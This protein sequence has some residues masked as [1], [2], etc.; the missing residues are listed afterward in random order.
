[1]TLHR[2][3]TDTTV[4]V[5]ADTQNDVWL[6]Q[7]GVTL[8][9]SGS[10]IDATATA[11]FRTFFIEG[12]VVA[13]Y[14]AG[15]ALGVGSMNRIV[16]G[17]EGAVSSSSSGINIYTPGQGEVDIRNSGDIYG[18]SEGIYAY[19]DTFK[20]VND[21]TIGGFSSVISRST[22][23]SIVNNGTMNGM[24]GLYSSS[25]GAT[26][27]VNHGIL[28]G[29]MMIDTVAGQ[30][31]TIVNTGKIVAVIAIDGSQGNDVVTNSGIIDG[32]VMLH[33]GNDKFSNFGSF[34]GGMDFGAGDDTLILRDGSHASGTILMGAG[35]DRIEV[36][37]GTVDGL[38]QGMS[39]NDVYVVRVAGA[40]LVE[41]GTDTDLVL[42]DLDWRLG[43][44]FEHLYLDG[45][46]DVTGRGNALANGISGNLGDNL[47]MGYAGD[48]TLEGGEGADRLDGGLGSDTAAY[49]DSGV[50]VTVDL[51]KGRARGGEAQ[52]DTF[53][54]IENAAGSRFGDT[55]LG[56]KAANSLYG[57]EGADRLDGRGGDDYL[58]GGGGS[59]TFVFAKRYGTDTI[60]DFAIAGDAADV[61]DISRMAGVD[62]FRDL[63]KNHMSTEGDDAVFTFDDGSVLVLTGRADTQFQANHFLI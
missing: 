56:S 49:T 18:F 62:S 53:V 59:D 54:S 40:Q 24:L 57:D 11:S 8:A 7:Q 44:N 36:L 63:V 34:N 15:I 37:G 48:D 38:V 1:M 16:V 55:L 51:E 46:A 31:N 39:G 4:T 6:V 33:N 23:N 30:T 35:N 20:L 14:G 43:G 27:V 25:A 52:G 41:S 28:N 60:V 10:A 29:G 9:T 12:H 2:I 17:S 45:D 22:N 26:S 5:I 3:D 42:T 21:G 19:M 50:A 32:L 47:L 58:Q 13:D 61:I